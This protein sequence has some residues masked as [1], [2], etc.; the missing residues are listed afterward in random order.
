[1]TWL[2]DDLLPQGD[3][4]MDSGMEGCGKT[5]FGNY[6]SVCIASGNDVFGQK[7][8]QGNV[9][10]IDEETPFPTLEQKLDRFSQGLGYSSYQDLPIRIRSMEGFR[11]NRKTERDKL[12]EEIT[13]F[14]PTFIRM[15]S[16]IAMIPSGRQG[17]CETDSGIGIS[18]RDDLNTI[19]KA[20]PG[21]SSLLSAHS[22]KPV[23]YWTIGEYDKA[24]M[25]SLVRGH[26][27]IV[28][29]AC[30][31]GF[32]IK[33]LSQYPDPL[34]LAVFVKARRSA[35]P[36][37]DA[38]L[39]LEMKEEGYGKGWARLERIP[40]P[41]IEPCKPAKELYPLFMDEEPHEAADIV[42]TCALLKKTECRVGV[43]ELLDHRIIVRGSEPQTYQLNVNG[44]RDEEYLEKLT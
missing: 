26:G 15:D 33:K 35:V 5:T 3:R 20:S 43:E 10:I 27:S 16:M 2:I 28:G 19:L 44:D 18:I 40:P 39:Y 41:P 13:S 23:E 22:C 29:E 24:E 17:L 38:V 30:D 12:L 36:M 1:M 11:F 7:V 34:R 8:Q 37:S 4:V 21:S 31:T 25:P 14:Q 9:L 42:R 6:L 32:A